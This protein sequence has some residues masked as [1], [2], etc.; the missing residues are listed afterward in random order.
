MKENKT[1][2]RGWLSLELTGVLL[3]I[4]VAI[5]GVVE[6]I[7]S[8]FSQN[9]ISN[10]LAN[11]NSIMTSTRSLLKGSTGYDY[12]SAANMTG[13]LIQYGGVP[14]TMDIHGT[15]SSGTATVTNVWG[16]KVTE[17]PVAISGTANAGFSLTYNKVPQQA[18]ATLTTK[19]SSGS[20][21]T[22]TTINGT[23]ITG[24]VSPAKAGTTC[25]ADTGGAG[26]NVI[27]WQSD[28]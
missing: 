20:M 9:D 19:L 25:N 18:C 6:W 12:S 8:S 4:I 15:A 16:G 1:I 5:I 22:Q 13:T 21:V 28:S 26:N 10:E 3:I 23:V 24:E 2:N 27:I 7:H 11:V 17:Q 14:S